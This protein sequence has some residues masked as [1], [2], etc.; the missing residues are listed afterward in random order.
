MV[1][2]PV[3][4]PILDVDQSL[5]MRRTNVAEAF[6]RAILNGRPVALH[7]GNPD[8]PPWSGFSL[9]RHDP[10]GLWFGVRAYQPEKG[11]SMSRLTL[12]SLAASGIVGIV[13][14]AT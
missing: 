11:L 9:L 12:I 1:R 13:L 2:R 3:S 4:G 7:V 6:Y 8:D 14:I 10:R 5:A